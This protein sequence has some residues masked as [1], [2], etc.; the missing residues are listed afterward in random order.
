[1]TQTPAVT[2]ASAATLA[3]LRQLMAESVAEFLATKAKLEA[4]AKTDE[5]EELNLELGELREQIVAATEALDAFAKTDESSIDPEV[6]AFWERLKADEL[7]VLAAIAGGKKSLAEAAVI[8][9]E[10]LRK[11]A[12]KADAVAEASPDD[13]DLGRKADE[14]ADKAGS[15]EAIAD[16]RK[17]EADTAEATAEAARAAAHRAEQAVEAA[18]AATEAAPVEPDPT[19]TDAD[20][21]DEDE[22]EEVIASSPTDPP[23]AT[24]APAEPEPPKGPSLPPRPVPTVL[25]AVVPDPGDATAKI[26]PKATVADPPAGPNHDAALSAAVDKAAA[27]TDPAPAPRAVAPPPFIPV[28]PVIGLAAMAGGP[29]DEPP[30]K[31]VAVA[32]PPAD[33]PAKGNGWWGW[34]KGGCLGLVAL[35]ALLLACALCAG[36]VGTT[37]IGGWWWVSTPAVVETIP[38]VVTPVPVAS[39]DTDEALADLEARLSA[40]E[41]PAAPPVPTAFVP[42]GRQVAGHGAVVVRPTTGGQYFLN[43]LNVKPAEDGA[44]RYR[45]KPVAWDCLT[46]NPGETTPA[47]RACPTVERIN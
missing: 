9:A 42:C 3:A 14:A 23:A 5:A 38:V 46:G 30:T 47:S 45:G 6:V 37:G 20:D 19:D 11:I 10:R 32:D 2:P 40:L 15:A 36:L 33:P 12:K 29:P 25:A 18:K 35:L 4:E 22:D 28:V 43:G 8:E 16:G 26:A 1:M 44:C 21:E 24:P 34:W 17:A 39:S 7:M 41:Q 27:D 31:K 13:D